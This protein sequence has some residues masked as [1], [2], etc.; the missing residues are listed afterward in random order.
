MNNQSKESLTKEPKL[1][2][3][4][5]LVAWGRLCGADRIGRQSGTIET[6]PENTNPSSPNE[7]FWNFLWPS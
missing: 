4:A 1:T 6:A 2:Q 5:M 7:S 3:H